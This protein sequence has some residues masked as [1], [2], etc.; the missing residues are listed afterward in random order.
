MP[1]CPSQIS[2]GLA[3]DQKQAFALTNQQF[4]DSSMALPGVGTNMGDAVLNA[5]LVF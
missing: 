4:I 1:L 3:L 5:L 2:H